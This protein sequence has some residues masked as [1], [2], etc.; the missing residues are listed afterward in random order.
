MKHSRNLVLISSYLTSLKSDK[1][2]PVEEK[3]KSKY[4]CPCANIEPFV[5]LLCTGPEKLVLGLKDF[6]VI[7]AEEKDF[8]QLVEE[9][10]LTTP[11]NFIVWQNT[12][13]KEPVM[14][15][16]R[17]TLAQKDQHITSKTV[18]YNLSLWSNVE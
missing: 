18:T 8:K 2:I 5:T 1:I 11:P 6:E 12:N 3:K 16:S 15:C 9:K 7:F 4:R 14:F 17:R 13:V 10:L